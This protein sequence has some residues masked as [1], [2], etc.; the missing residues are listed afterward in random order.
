MC[1]DT[2]QAHLIEFEPKV[3]RSSGVC[4]SGKRKNCGT[5]TNVC[6]GSSFAGISLAVFFATV[7]AECAIGSALGTWVSGPPLSIEAPE[8]PKIEAGI[9]SHSR[10]HGGSIPH[11]D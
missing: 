3:C 10:G 7:A 6:I 2:R 9:V 8:V 11:K 1:C 5:D 4:L